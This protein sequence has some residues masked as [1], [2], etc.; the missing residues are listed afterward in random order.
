MK[1]PAHLLERPYLRPVYDE[2]EFVVRNVYRLYGGWWDGNPANLKPARDA[3]VSFP[4]PR[5]R[6]RF[7]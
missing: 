4:S 3:E 1:P 7:A 2:P 6:K 5:W